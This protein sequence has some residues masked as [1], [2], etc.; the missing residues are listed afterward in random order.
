[1][2]QYMFM[3]CLFCRGENDLQNCGA[4]S[5][6]VGYDWPGTNDDDSDWFLVLK[7]GTESSEVIIYLYDY[8]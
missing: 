5:I 3:P 7:R 8:Y 2:L 6:L 1:M 4:P